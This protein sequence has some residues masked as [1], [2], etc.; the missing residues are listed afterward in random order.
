MVQQTIEDLKVLGLKGMLKAYEIQLDQSSASSMSFESRF[1]QIVD[2]EKCERNNRKVSRLLKAAK[3]RQNSACLE[4]LNYRADRCIDQSLINSLSTCHWINQRQNVIITGAT[5]TG[6]SW[7]ACAIGKQACRNGLSS[8][9]I[10][11]T[12]LY[13]HISAAM[14]DGSLLKFR[15]QITKSNLL[16]IDDFGIGGIDLKIGPILLEIIDQQT[17]HG[18]LIITSQ[19]PTNKWYDLFND[20]TIADA[21][22]DRVLHRTHFIKLQGSSMRKSLSE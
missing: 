19:F 5:G 2:S 13:E 3:L 18:A 14:L 4:D 11:A 1:S 16:I 10:T 7:L 6:K 9:F 22:L 15:R 20:P 12:H 8:F 21:I 17:L